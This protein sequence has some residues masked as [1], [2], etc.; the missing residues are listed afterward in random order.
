MTLNVPLNTS[1]GIQLHWLS[2]GHFS[3]TFYFSNQKQVAAP[4]LYVTKQMSVTFI[5]FQYVYKRTT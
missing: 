1:K 4:S 2:R 3:L 5:I